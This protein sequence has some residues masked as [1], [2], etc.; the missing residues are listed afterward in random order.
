MFHLSDYTYGLPA[1]KIAQMPCKSRSESKLLQIRRDSG[2]LT[3]HRFKDISDLLRKD[4][5]L[6]INNTRVIPARLMGQ[7]AS[8]GQI[9]RASCRERVWGYL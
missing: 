6:V 9:G 8:G 3:H 1:E 4:D 5:L 2:V 7:K